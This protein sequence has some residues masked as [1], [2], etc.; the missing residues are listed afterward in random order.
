MTS[1]T[2]PGHLGRMK[3]DLRRREEPPIPFFNKKKLDIHLSTFD[4][5][6]LFSLVIFA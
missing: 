6:T 1:Q 5:G 4:F 3:Q 2:G